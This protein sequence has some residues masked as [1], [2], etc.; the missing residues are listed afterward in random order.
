MRNSR[1]T[2]FCLVVLHALAASEALLADES[3]DVLR[4]L[5]TSWRDYEGIAV[6]AKIEK[7]ENGESA[8]EKKIRAIYGSA[9]SPASLRPL[10]IGY[11]MSNPGEPHL[12]EEELFDWC[13][14][15]SDGIQGQ[16]RRRY[17]SQPNPGYRAS[18]MYVTNEIVS[19]DVALDCFNRMIIGGIE[20]YAIDESDSFGRINELQN[21]ISLTVLGDSEFLGFPC[22]R[23]RFAYNRALAPEA[24]GLTVEQLVSL[25]PTVRVLSTLDVYGDNEAIVESISSSLSA[26]EI[27]EMKI[28]SGRL[29]PTQASFFGAKSLED[30]TRVLAFR[31]KVETVESLP[32]NFDGLWEFDGPPGTLY[33][34]PAE[35]AVRQNGKR[36]SRESLRR[37]VADGAESEYSFVAYTDTQENAIREYLVAHNAPAVARG[38]SKTRLLFILLNVVVIS[39]VGVYLFVLKRR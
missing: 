4:S 19:P 38:V 6:T 30:A 25:E 35:S 23:I 39:A 26:C 15:W 22:K 37:L 10:C 29:I 17:I 27:E 18:L 13:V 16:F 8:G 34:G 21:K 7:F 12:D 20:G 24:E 1:F 14:V 9:N 33:T 36:A 11:L 2:I 28:F 32:D 5:L 3:R 31:V